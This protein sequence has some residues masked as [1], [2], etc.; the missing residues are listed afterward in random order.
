MEGDY[1]YTGESAK[2]VVKC[3]HQTMV[4]G[5]AH[6][7]SRLAC[8]SLLILIGLLRPCFWPLV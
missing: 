8:D 7:V 6:T 1:S 5:H 2:F 3:M 4:Q